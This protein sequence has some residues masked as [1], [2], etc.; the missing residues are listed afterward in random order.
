[1]QHGRIY[2]RLQKFIAMSGI[3]SRRKAEELILEGRVKVNG[4]VIKELGT[5]IDPEKDIVFVD[6][7]R[8]KAVEKK[9]Y[10][11]LNKPEGYVTSLKDT[12]NNKVVLDLVKNIKERI[13]PVGRLDKDTS[14]LLIMTNDGDLAY[15]LTHPK[16]EVWKKYIALVKGH[17]DNTKLEMLRNG[18]D[19][20]GRLTSK[21]HVKLVKKNTRTTLLEIA[22]HE[23]RN[24]Q[25]RKMC[26]HIGHP[27]IDLKRVSIGNIRLDGLEKGK[28]R[29]LNEKEVEYLKKI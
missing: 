22:I 23:G 5:K 29:Y 28:W 9:I 7:K 19:I 15:K 20:D 14:G 26:E 10:I 11:I 4:I 24:R 1:M 2:M 3:T 18:I 16:H 12:H 27:V 25:V 6:N 21:A 13:F 17:P 8:I